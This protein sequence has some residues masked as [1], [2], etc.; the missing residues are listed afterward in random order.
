MFRK[1]SRG[2]LAA[3]FTVVAVYLVAS[4]VVT[5]D[6]PSNRTLQASFVGR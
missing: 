2:Q 4:F 1:I 3:I 6:E 5:S